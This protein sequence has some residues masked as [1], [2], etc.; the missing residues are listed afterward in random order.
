MIQRKRA[1]HHILSR[2][3]P[4]TAAHDAQAAKRRVSRHG[5]AALLA[6]LGPAAGFAVLL[7][8]ASHTARFDWLTHLMSWPW[9]LWTIGGCGTLATVGGVLDWRHHRSG[10]TAVGRA[11]HRAHVAAL[12]GGGL[13]LFALMA[14]ASASVRPQ[15][16]LLPIIVVVLFTTVLVCLDEFR[17]HRRAGRFETLTHRLLVF[18]NLAAWLAWMHWVYV[19]S[20]GGAMGVG[21]A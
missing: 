6:M 4:A 21:S 11:E 10:A 8:L 13:P 19:R 5:G 20:A 7:V 1:R 17:Y 3:T 9:E 2:M 15:D 12:A 18:G 16:W 14:A